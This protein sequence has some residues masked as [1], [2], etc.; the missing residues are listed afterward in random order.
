[1][2]GLAGAALAA[3]LIVF[4]PLDAAAQLPPEPQAQPMRPGG[5]PPMPPPGQG[6]QLTPQQVYQILDAF[7]ITEAQRVLQIGDP[8]F[9]EFFRRMQ[10]L[11]MVQRRHTNQRQGLL[12]ELRRMVGPNAPPSDEGVLMAK[13]RELD[14]LDTRFQNM[15]R[16][17]VMAIDMILQPHQR[18]HFRI[19]L[20]QVERQKVDLMMRA[21]QGGPGRPGRAGQQPI[22]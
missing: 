21:R 5:P 18:A 9:A 8:Q 1:M 7:V 13:V 19:F 12:G 20:E 11:Q 2:K 3:L 6:D 16:Q 17:A 22:R 14:D 4:A 15:E 10:V